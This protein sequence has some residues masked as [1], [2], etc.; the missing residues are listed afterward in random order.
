MN[1]S[2]KIFF[3]P[4]MLLVVSFVILTPSEISLAQE[5][6]D[7]ST[8]KGKALFTQTCAPCHGPEL[9]GGIAQSLV[10]GIWQYGDNKT[11]MMRHIKNGI[12][13]VGMPAFGDV[14]S[15]DQIKSL[16][17]F[18]SEAAEE[19]GA[20][21]PPLPTHIQTQQYEIDIHVYAEGLETPWAIDFLDE[22]TA[23]ITERPGNLRIVKY[24]LLDP[25]PI[26]GIPKVLTRGQGGLMDVAINPD[27]SENG[28]IYLSYSHGIPSTVDN[29]VLGMTRIVRGK[30]NGHTWTDEEILF[31]AKKEHYIASRVHFG[32]RIVFDK[33]GYLYFSIGER[34]QPDDAQDLG[35][36]NGK[37]HRIHPDGSI[38]EDNPFVNQAG[39]YPSIYSY[40][41]RN[42]QGLAIHPETDLLWATEH[43]PMGGDELNLPKIGLNYG[44]PRVSYGL[45][46]DGSIV[47]DK[48]RDEGFEEPI[49]YWRPSIA[50]CGL[51]F[52]QGDAFSKWQNQLLVGALVY[53]EIQL[54]TVTAERVMHSEVILKNAG[55]VRDIATG[56]DGF[57]YVVLNNPHIVIRLRPTRERTFK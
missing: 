14:L 43:G 1:L 47:S 9:Q 18:I 40:G 30:I 35:L 34:G 39:A 54:L 8:L 32:S 53:E 41:H 17:N 10:D 20:V 2:K 57:I 26:K 25:K 45:N 27:Y 31:T 22:F 42:P 4:F 5:L 15:G 11:N 19:A 16:V 33:A 23:L 6:Q 12:T 56:P 55:R 13:Q 51:D 28:W 37:I 7:I 29:S 36:P 44:W 52:Y 38:P 24:G 48:V 46:Y 50:T 49:Y 3:T 21:K